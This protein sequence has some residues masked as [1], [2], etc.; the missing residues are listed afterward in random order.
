MTRTFLYFQKFASFQTDHSVFP[1]LLGLE[2]LYQTKWLSISYALF[3]QNFTSMQRS[4]VSYPHVWQAPSMARE[5]LKIKHFLCF[6]HHPMDNSKISDHYFSLFPTRNK[7][8]WSSMSS[9]L[10]WTR[11]S[12]LTSWRSWADTISFVWYGIRHGC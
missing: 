2:P 4:L 12:F 8:S 6:F 11:F 1:F 5:N 10:F 9:N 7:S 3:S